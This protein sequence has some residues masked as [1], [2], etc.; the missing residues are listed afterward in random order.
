MGLLNSMR[1]ACWK[2]RLSNPRVA[3]SKLAQAVQHNDA[4]ALLRCLHAGV[5][6][7]RSSDSPA[8]WPTS[9]PTLAEWLVE[10]DSPSLLDQVGLLPGREKAMAAC[11]RLDRVDCL[12]VLW[13][14]A[15]VDPTQ[16][17]QL[18]LLAMEANAPGCAR[19]L[20]QSLSSAPPGPDPTPWIHRATTV[21][22]AQALLCE[23][24]C[25]SAREV[26]E[27]GL[28]APHTWV[29]NPALAEQ[30]RAMIE[31]IHAHEPD[32]ING[33]LPAL[34]L[35]LPDW[36]KAGMGEEARH[37]ARRLMELGDDV[38]TDAL[39]F[40][41]GAGHPPYLPPP[42]L[43]GLLLEQVGLEGVEACDEQGYSV[44]M[45]LESAPATAEREVLLALCRGVRMEH[46]LEQSRAG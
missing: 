34:L 23:A 44:E 19:L 32:L 5:L 1:L 17:A 38:P 26:D 27:S 20:V 22:M 16:G 30:A 18:L 25:L 6:P 9:C 29:C 28:A 12:A 43:F 31:C 8:Y 11:C 33:C 13:A 3:Q 14:Q 40:A 10:L 45:R 21:E 42:A 24:S 39:H 36:D 41:M 35:A 46:L 15:C 37:L 7:L 4:K 2:K